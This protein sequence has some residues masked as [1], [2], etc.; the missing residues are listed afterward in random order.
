[1]IAGGI[2]ASVLFYVNNPFAAVGS[3]ASSLASDT[4]AD[5]LLPAP[6]PPPPP[7]PPPPAFISVVDTSAVQIRAGAAEYFDF[8][9][10]DPRT[11]VLHGRV[12]G[13]A[14]GRRDFN[15]FVFDDDGFA[16]W[17]NGNQAHTYFNESQ[18]SSVTLNVVLPSPGSYHLV[19][20]NRFSVFTGKT[21]QIRN[22]QVT[23]S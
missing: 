3:A 7:P 4:P 6:L 9:L 11:C 1:M 8:A 23:C 20:S 21:V 10:S 15:V 5:S 2:A 14:G 17:A 12:V 18:T 13:L 16:N 22:A 19:V